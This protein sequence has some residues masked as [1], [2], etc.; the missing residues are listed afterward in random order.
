[1][2]TGEDETPDSNPWLHNT[3]SI[4]AVYLV[5]ALGWFVSYKAG[6]WNS[7]DIDVGAPEE[8]KGTMEKVGL[9][10]GYV[11]AVCYLC[12]RI[13]QIIKNW[14]EKSCEGTSLWVS[15]FRECNAC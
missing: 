12:A 7:P 1:M 14:Q 3:L 2:V 9:F 10:L 5:G 6:A 8:V 15:A 4:F 13:P 11:S